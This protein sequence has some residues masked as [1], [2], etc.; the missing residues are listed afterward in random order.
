M[1]WAP[2]YHGGTR[3]TRCARCNH[4]AGGVDRQADHCGGRQCTRS[5]GLS[6][7]SL[8]LGSWL[9]KTEKGWDEKMRKVHPNED[10]FLS[11]T[12]RCAFLT[13]ISF[14]FPGDI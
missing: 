12:A 4:S 10:A 5:A 6:R 7:S 13:L 9:L 14:D 11:P 3:D 1:L 2:C 8:Y